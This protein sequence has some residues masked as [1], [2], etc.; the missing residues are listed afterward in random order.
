MSLG[1]AREWFFHLDDEDC[2]LIPERRRD[3]NRLGFSVQLGADGGPR[4]IHAVPAG[5]VSPASRAPQRI[6]RALLEMG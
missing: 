3:S 4:W 1:A 2:K 6:R 5:A